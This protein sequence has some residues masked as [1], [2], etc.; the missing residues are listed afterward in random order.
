[1]TNHRQAGCIVF[2]NGKCGSATLCRTL[3]ASLFGVNQPAATVGRRPGV[4]Y[5][6]ISHRVVHTHSPEV[7][8]DAIGQS[9]YGTIYVF[10]P[11]RH[12][13]DSLP[14]AHYQHLYTSG[15]KTVDVPGEIDRFHQRLPG[16]VETYEKRINSLGKLLGADLNGHLNSLKPLGGSGA[17]RVYLMTLKYEEIDRWPKILNEAFRRRL[18]RQ[19]VNQ[20]ISSTKFH[21]SYQQFKSRIRYGAGERAVINRYLTLFP[22]IYSQL[23]VKRGYQKYQ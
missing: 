21:A 14:S 17:K 7:V 19:L 9:R 2:S 8:R 5:F 22:K 1:M 23:E 16:R 13:A 4:D 6:Q 15:A 18:V 3:K 10:V 11:L 12:P 20:N